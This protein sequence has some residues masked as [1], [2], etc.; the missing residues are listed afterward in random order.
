MTTGRIN[1][2][3]GQN[4]LGDEQRYSSHPAQSEQSQ[5]EMGG[6]ATVTVAEDSVTENQCTYV[7][8]DC[9][10]RFTLWKRNLA[11]DTAAAGDSDSFP[12]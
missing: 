10:K 2:V 8:S 9:A 7:P 11:D 4:P 3:F 6:D 5:T 1:Q 12:Q